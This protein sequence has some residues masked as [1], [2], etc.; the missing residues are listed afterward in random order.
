MFL[1]P[2]LA[3]EF[4]QDL[5]CFLN[6]LLATLAGFFE[7][8]IFAMDVAN[9]HIT[10]ITHKR[11]NISKDRDLNMK[12]YVKHIRATLYAYTYTELCS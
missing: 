1:F 12:K 5:D 8:G 2:S 11:T 10:I 9:R 4:V 6:S 7:I 3:N